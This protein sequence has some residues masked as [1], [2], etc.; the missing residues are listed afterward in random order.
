MSLNLATDNSKHGITLFEAV[1]ALMLASLL[2]VVLMRLTQGSMGQFS[3]TQKQSEYFLSLG[4]F[5][6]TLRDDVRMAHDIKLATPSFLL[7]V[8]GINGTDTI[9]YSHIGKNQIE[10]I[11]QGRRQ[12]FT[13]NQDSG[14]IGTFV[15]NIREVTQ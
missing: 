13:I 8:D 6:E 9:F 12:V 15:F 14:L 3:T 11:F 5:L 2:G 4:I 1:V 7:E 10:R